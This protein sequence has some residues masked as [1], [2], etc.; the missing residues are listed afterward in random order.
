MTIEENM[1]KVLEALANKP[2]EEGDYQYVTNEELQ[3]LTGLN[4]NELND[5]VT[6]LVDNSYLEWRRYM[7]TAP[8]NFHSVNITP[9]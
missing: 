8:Y 4:T 6:M 3:K 1:Y 7:G 5:A 2:R 9:F